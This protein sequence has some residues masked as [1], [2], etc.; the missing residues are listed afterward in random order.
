MIT[1]L[2]FMF[3]SFLVLLAVKKPKILRLWRNRGAHNQACRDRKNNPYKTIKILK[4]GTLGTSV[5]PRSRLAILCW[6]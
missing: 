2:K 4:V 1:R 3:P 5:L 6:I